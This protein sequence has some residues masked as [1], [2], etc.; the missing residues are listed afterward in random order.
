[1]WKMLHRSQ[2][3]FRLTRLS[4]VLVLFVALAGVMPVVAQTFYGAMLGL[5]TDASG[6]AIPSA[7]VNLLNSATGEKRT[8]ETDASGNYRFIN[9]VPGTYRLE[10]EKAGF[11]RLTR[12]A[13]DVNV[14]SQVREDARIEV[15]DTSQTVEV[16]AQAT[17]L[18][19][20]SAQLSQ[21]VEGR[22]VTDTPLN[23]RNVLNLVT[24]VPGV[25]AIGNSFS[26]NPMGNASTNFF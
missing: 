2:S 12:D 21:V 19:T 14:D 6:A 15:G 7:M 5:V 3:S 16:T 11:K 23:G 8:A 26:G 1:M 20:D 9:L 24:L 13:I 25:V 17:L 18:Q 4:G 10:I 22:T